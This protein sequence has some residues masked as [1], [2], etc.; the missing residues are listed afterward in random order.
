MDNQSS[1]ALETVRRKPHSKDKRE[2][3]RNE[4]K[5]AVLPNRGQPPQMCL[6]EAA[7]HLNLLTNGGKDLTGSSTKVS[8]QNSL[9]S[10]HPS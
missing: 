2:G 6:H 3:P 5:M 4:S 7:K 10:N 9:L 1:V 8:R